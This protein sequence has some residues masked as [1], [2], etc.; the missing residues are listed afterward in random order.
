[1]PVRLEGDPTLSPE[2]WLIPEGGKPHSLGMIRRGEAM[3][4][5]IPAELRAASAN[6]LLAI[7]LEPAGSQAHEAPTGPVVAKGNV[8]RL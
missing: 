7:S 6:G 5:N 2:L 1:V 3:V 8:V 4:V